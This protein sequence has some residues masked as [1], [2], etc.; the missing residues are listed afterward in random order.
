MWDSIVD[1]ARKEVFILAY[2]V[3][4]IAVWWAGEQAFHKIV[5]R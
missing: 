4:V 5:G 3:V 2:G 1:L